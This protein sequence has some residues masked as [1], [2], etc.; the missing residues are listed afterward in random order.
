MSASKQLISLFIFSISAVVCAQAAWSQSG[1]STVDTGNWPDHHAGKYAQRYSPLDQINAENVSELAL[2][3]SFDTAP[4]GPSAEFN[5]PSTPI[6]NDHPRLSVG[7]PGCK[8]GDSRFAF[9]REWP[10]GP[11]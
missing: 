11:V 10:R 6:A 8:D 5:N 7:F 2:A 1:S 9:W 3:W 4:I